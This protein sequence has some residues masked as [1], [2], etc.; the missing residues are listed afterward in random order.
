MKIN[1]IMLIVS[2][3]IS[4]L[5]GYGFWAGTHVLMN[6]IVAGVC[7]LLT[8]GVLLS[9]SSKAD[10][11]TSANIKVVAGIFFVVLLIEQIIFTFAH[12]IAPYIIVTGILLL[13]YLIIEYA[14]C[15]AN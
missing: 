13:I 8:L 4:A 7:I 10:G 15:K 3:A 14:I 1:P 2:I 6:T 12:V 9:L 5:A 11:R